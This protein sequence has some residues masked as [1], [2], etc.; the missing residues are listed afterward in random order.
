MSKSYKQHL[1]MHSDISIFSCIK[2]HKRN[3]ISGKAKQN[4]TITQ[5]KMVLFS[6]G[7]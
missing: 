1:L 3:L 7:T 6:Y 5:S 4:N 2:L